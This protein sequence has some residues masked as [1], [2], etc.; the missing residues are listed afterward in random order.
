MNNEIALIA[1]IGPNQVIGI[2]NE[3]PWHSKQDFYHFKTQTKGYPCIFGDNTFFNLP[4]YPLKNRLN[5]V[6]SL[7]YTTTEVIECSEFNCKE[8]P[9][10]YTE[11]GAYIKAKSIEAAITLGKNFSKIFICGGKSIYKYCLENNL[12][13]TI[14]LTKIISPSLQKEINEN[15]KNYVYFPIDLQEYL[16][17]NWVRV[18]F[19]Y[20]KDE[21]PEEN[22]D[23]TVLFQKWIKL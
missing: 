13:N 21:L 3:L 14:Y 23:V 7:E 1:A 15:P 16:S 20:K 19:E 9:V 8:T 12:I 22:D 18:P 11:T 6:T 2:G 5:I 17:K 10:K 4:K